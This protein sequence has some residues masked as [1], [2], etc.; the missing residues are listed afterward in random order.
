[1]KKLIITISLVFTVSIVNAGE[2]SAIGF[3]GCGEFLSHCDRDKLHLDCQAQNKW[4]QGYISGVSWEGDYKFDTNKAEQMNVKYAL[5]K[6]CREKP[7]KN[8]RDA[9][10]N[11][12]LQIRIK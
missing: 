5:I 2:S 11:I 7:L 9:S 8:L 12:L 1:M 6:Y 4:A 10:E 3:L